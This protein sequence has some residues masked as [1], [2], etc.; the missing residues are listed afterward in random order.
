VAG[1]AC[2]APHL[3][4][5]NVRAGSAERTGKQQC[6]WAEQ[7]PEYITLKAQR[8]KTVGVSLPVDTSTST[9]RRRSA[10]VDVTLD[11]RKRRTWDDQPESLADAFSLGHQHPNKAVADVLHD[12]MEEML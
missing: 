5:D 12:M 1:G 9:G 4:P 6:D 8:P 10:Q 3:A 11:Y 7:R 2:L